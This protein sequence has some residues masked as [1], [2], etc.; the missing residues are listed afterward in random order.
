MSDIDFRQKNKLFIFTTIKYD[1]CFN[2]IMSQACRTHQ[3][4]LNDLENLNLRVTT[5]KLFILQHM[6]HVSGHYQVE[7]RGVYNGEL[8]EVLDQKF[9]NRP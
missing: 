6:I 7:V 5:S 8:D 9:A 2:P 1:T 3:V 4:N